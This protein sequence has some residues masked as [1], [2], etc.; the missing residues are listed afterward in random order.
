MVI[1]ALALWL[2]FFP[3]VCNNCGDPYISVDAPAALKVDVRPR[4]AIA[5]TTIVITV[6]AEAKATNRALYI[7]I[8]SE[9]YYRSSLDPDFVGE[10]S[11]RIRKYTYELRAPG[12]YVITVWLARAAPDKDE[13]AHVD[14]CLAGPDVGC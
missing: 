8:D 11:P 5:P 14:L 6:E 9:N 3:V 10:E 4:V 13:K 2:S 12:R 7:F 1:F